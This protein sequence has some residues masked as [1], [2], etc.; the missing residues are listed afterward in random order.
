MIDKSDIKAMKCLLRTAD[1]QLASDLSCKDVFTDEEAEKIL[2]RKVWFPS[3]KP[4]LEIL[5]GK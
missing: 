1:Q 3:F 2:G 5:S 4:D